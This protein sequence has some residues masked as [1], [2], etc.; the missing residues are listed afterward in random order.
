MARGRMV[1]VRESFEVGKGMRLLRRDM[2]RCEAVAEGCWRGD[3]GGRNYYLVKMKP[4][5]DIK[6]AS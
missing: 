4:M 3:F 5:T 1:R 2:A 6:V